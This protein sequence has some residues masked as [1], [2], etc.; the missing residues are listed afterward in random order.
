MVAARRIFVLE[1]PL[2]MKTRAGVRMFEDERHMD[3]EA[4]LRTFEGIYKQILAA[5][6]NRLDGF[7]AI[8][9]GYI[10]DRLANVRH[11]LAQLPLLRKEP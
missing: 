5:R 1:G 6:P 11:Q 7:A 2:R 3:L 4:N 8:Y 9:Y 10:G